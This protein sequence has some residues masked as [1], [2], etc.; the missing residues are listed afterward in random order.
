[1]TSLKQNLFADLFTRDH[2]I[3]KSEFEKFV[4]KNII[5]FYS[6]W[7]KNGYTPKSLWKSAGLNGFLCPDLPKEYGGDGHQDFRYNIIINEVLSRLGLKGVSFTLHSDAAC[8]YILN[9]CS[10]EIKKL[11]LPACFKGEKILSLAFTEPTGGSDLGNIKT[12]AVDKKSHFVLTGKKSFI[13]NAY[14]HDISIVLAK[15]RLD[16]NMT[17]LSL[18]LVD[19]QLAGYKKGPLVKKLGLHARD[20]GDLTFSNV[21]ISK[22]NIIG[23]KNRALIYLVKLLPRERLSVSIHALATGFEVFDQTL[24]YA[25]NREAFGQPIGKFQ[26]NGF[27]LAEMKTELTIGESFVRDCIRDILKNDLTNEK[28]AM[29]KWWT[30]DLLQKIIEKC[31][32][33]HGG[34]GYLADSFVGKA[35]LDSRVLTIYAGT[36][37]IMKNIIMK[38]MG[39]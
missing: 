34:S 30:T 31:L 37:E 19:A 6:N 26:S 18:F 14:I 23:V 38:N 24:S 12:T 22:N 33:M 3:Y 29:A 39:L 32:Q 11:I 35:Y 4:T 8:P 20:V 9:Y 5:P 15:T 2:L 13:A 10:A 36:N 28:V 17:G 16:S 7:E 25:R 27:K 1:M 21:K